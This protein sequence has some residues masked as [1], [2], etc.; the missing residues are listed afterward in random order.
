[1]QTTATSQ[2][3]PSR[4]RDRYI[5][6]DLLLHVCRLF[7]TFHTFVDVKV[8]VKVAVPCEL[9]L[10]IQPHVNSVSVNIQQV[11]VDCQYI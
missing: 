11:S 10:D 3:Y 8:G 4:E 6:N 7:E 1:M 9:S 2:I 5:T